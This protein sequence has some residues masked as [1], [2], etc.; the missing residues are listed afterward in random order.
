M[1]IDVTTA[2][3]AEGEP[4]SYSRLPDGT[5]VAGQAKQTQE[6]TLQQKLDAMNSAPTEPSGYELPEIRVD[7]EPWQP[8]TEETAAV[9][10]LKAMADTANL[11]AFEFANLAEIISRPGYAPMSEEAADA[12]LRREWAGQFDA[13]ATLVAQVLD[14]VESKHPGAMRWL[15][16]SG[17]G[18][19]LDLIN[20][21]WRAASRRK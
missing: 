5:T 13:R 9:D 7:G 4:I 11:P 19:N 15:E 12:H 14:E 3:P 17:L 1:L 10:I 16:A 2:P 20:A 21:I 18:N 8:S 6:R